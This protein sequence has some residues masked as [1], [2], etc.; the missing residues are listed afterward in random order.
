MRFDS[1]SRRGESTLSCECDLPRRHCLK[2]PKKHERGVKLADPAITTEPRGLTEST[3]MLADI[4][5]TAAVPGRCGPRCMRDILRGSSSS[6]WRYAAQAACERKT[7]HSR[8]EIQDLR[9]QDSVYRPRVWTADGRPRP[10]VTR[11]MQC[12]ADIATSRYY[13]LMSAAA[14][15]HWWKHEVQIALLRHRAA[16]RTIFS[17]LISARTVAPQRTHR[18][19]HQPL[20]ASASTRRRWRR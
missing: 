20:G 12:A 5:T 13:Q 8:C 4:F 9:Q 7:T 17:S 2:A 16:A 15:E 14:L 19:N 10:A 11:R 1:A 6:S 3:S 18:P